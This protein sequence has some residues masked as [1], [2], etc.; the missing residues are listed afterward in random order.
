MVTTWIS[1]GLRASVEGGTRWGVAFH[2][3]RSRQCRHWN[4]I[5][6]RKEWVM[7]MCPAQAVE[8]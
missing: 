4:F 1:C 8:L 3:R 7:K 2:E 5:V 6:M